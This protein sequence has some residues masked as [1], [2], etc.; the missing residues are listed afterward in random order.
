MQSYQF[1][2]AQKSSGKDNMHAGMHQRTV[3]YA[4]EVDVSK[5]LEHLGEGAP[6]T[7][8]LLALLPERPKE[9]VVMAQAAQDYATAMGRPGYVP[10]RLVQKLQHHSWCHHIL[11]R[12]RPGQS[13]L[14]SK[15]SWLVF[16]QQVI[17]KHSCKNCHSSN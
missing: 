14:V 4:Q 6:H 16:I 15:M 8:L 2:D 7:V 13:L 1:F 10:C 12:S 11:N 5:P 17:Q 9:Q 3:W